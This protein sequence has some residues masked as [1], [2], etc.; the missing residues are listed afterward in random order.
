MI[1]LVVLLSLVQ[2]SAA[3][4]RLFVAA[5]P[6]LVALC[7]GAL[8]VLA[9]LRLRRVAE[10]RLRSE[11]LTRLRISL[12]QIDALTDLQFEFLLRDLM[13][14]DGCAARQVGQQGDQAADVIAQ[15]PQCGRIVLQA[16]HTK[17]GGKVGSQVMYQVKGTAGPVHGADHAV[18]VTNGAF[19]R[20]AKAWGD[21]H[22]VY[23]ID[24]ERLRLWA[25]HGA[26]LHDLL[27]LPACTRKRALGLGRS[28]A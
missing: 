20:D 13:I 26:V 8:V 22:K 2:A 19:T 27:H 3:L 21:K 17:V 28:V 14:R 23:W 24:R 25:E 1:A 18:V 15:D 11:R 7:I 12:A 4:G 9:V 5:W 16:K 6:I 10:S